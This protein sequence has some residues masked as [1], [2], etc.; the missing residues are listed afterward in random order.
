[1][2][3]AFLGVMMLTLL[4]G[5]VFVRHPTVVID[6]GTMAGR[7]YRVLAGLTG[8]IGERR[9]TEKGDCRGAGRVGWGG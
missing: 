3:V 2:T 6:P 7:I 8:E 1:M 5:V 4:Y 9:D